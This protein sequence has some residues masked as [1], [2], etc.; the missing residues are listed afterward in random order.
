MFEEGQLDF[1]EKDASKSLGIVLIVASTFISTVIYYELLVQLGF[2]FGNLTNLLESLFTLFIV[3]GIPVGAF[4]CG[5]S[6]IR[7]NKR[8]LPVGILVIGVPLILIGLSIIWWRIEMGAPVWVA[9][10]LFLFIGSLYEWWGYDEY[11]QDRHIE[12][13]LWWPLCVIGS[14]FVLVIFDYLVPEVI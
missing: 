5:L 3:Y 13:E 10:L 9:G 1:L 6:L 14:F 12:I 4:L 7:V 2:N 11:K 8:L